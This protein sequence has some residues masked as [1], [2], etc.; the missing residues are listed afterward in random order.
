MKNKTAKVII[1]C[2]LL[3]IIGVFFWV[4]NQKQSIIDKGELV[5]LEL[6]PQDPRSLMQGDYMT[7]Y[8]TLYN[9]ISMEK[10]DLPQQGYLILELDSLK[11]GKLVNSSALLE[12]S[13]PG[14]VLIKYK[15]NKWGRVVLSADYFY[16]QETKADIYENAQYAALKVDSKGNCI[17]VGLYDKAVKPIL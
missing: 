1:V 5:L 2:T 6:A 16:F 9:E 3:L 11:V 17:I 15:K 7:L 12:N 4:A 14:Q 8:Y 13:S 10:L